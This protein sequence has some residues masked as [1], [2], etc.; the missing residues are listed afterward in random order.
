MTLADDLW[1]ALELGDRGQALRTATA[2]LDGGVPPTELLDVVCDAQRRVGELWQR[3]Q[4]SIAQ[5]HAATAISEDVVAAVGARNERT[6]DRGSVLVACTDGEWHA[7][8]ARV[9]AEALRLDGW[10]VQY[11]G[12]SVPARHLASMVEDL[13]PDVVCISCSLSSSL[14]TVRDMVEAARGAG[15]PVLVG[16]AGTGPG[17]RWALHLGATAWAPTANEAVALLYDGEVPRFVEPP[18]PVATDEATA[19]HSGEE[20]LVT[21]LTG[22]GWGREDAVA[23]VRALS[24]ALLVDDADVFAQ[25]VAWQREV[26]VHAGVSQ[27]QV[28][29]ALSLLADAG[30]PRT[31]EVVAAARHRG[32]VG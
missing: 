30:G 21:D 25:H 2:A 7:L 8:P 31:A 6:A 10:R 28:D 20:H 13:G 27:E 11:L 22:R 19:L 12:A 4:W 5:E 18:P 3:G 17:G 24:V 29:T 9:L 23:L 14:W 26:G 15:T 16:G 32:G 1:Q